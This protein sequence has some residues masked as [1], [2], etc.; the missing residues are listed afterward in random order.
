MASFDAD[1]R[2]TLTTLFAWTESEFLQRTEGS[3]IRRIGHERWLRNVAV[4]M[5]NALRV[6][7]GEQADTLVHSLKQ[8]LPEASALLAEHIDWALV[9]ASITRVTIPEAFD[10]GLDQPKTGF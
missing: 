7:K 4:A 6:V 9:Q 1:F 2:E 5:G 8:R 3:P 10:N